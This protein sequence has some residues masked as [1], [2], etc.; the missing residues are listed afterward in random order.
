MECKTEACEVTMILTKVA[1]A[2]LVAAILI[3]L[4]F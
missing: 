3:V 4:L 2:I 1:G